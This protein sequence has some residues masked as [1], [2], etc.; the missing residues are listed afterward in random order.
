MKPK[1]YPSASLFLE[2]LVAR[3][4]LK[5][6]PPKN[7]LSKLMQKNRKKIFLLTTIVIVSHLPRSE[8]KSKATDQRAGRIGKLFTTNAKSSCHTHRDSLDF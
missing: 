6:R 1:T 5:E 2:V 8:A 7:F 3:Y 4:L